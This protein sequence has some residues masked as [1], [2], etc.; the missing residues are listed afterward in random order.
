[1]RQ[2]KIAA[3][4]IFSLLAIS[5]IGL[6]TFFITTGN[7]FGIFS[8]GYKGEAVLAQEFSVL[9]KDTKNIDLDL[10]HNAMDVFV[11][12]GEGDKIVYKEYLEKGW[13]DSELSKVSNDGSTL[14]VSGQRRSFNI[15]F[16]SVNNQYAEI[17]IPADYEKDIT[18]NT[19]SGNVY[20]EGKQIFGEYVNINTSSGDV[21]LEEVTAD[22]ISINTI[23]GNVYGDELLGER[24]FNTSSGDVKILGGKGNTMGN[25]S[26]GNIYLSEATGEVELSTN[27]GDVKLQLTKEES[28]TFL[29]ET[30][31][32]DINTYFDEELTMNEDRNE[33]KGTIGAEGTYNVKIGTSSG[34]VTVFE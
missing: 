30:S 7:G 14:M 1:M 12:V 19:S 24:E 22:Y 25:T 13:S 17:Y 32:G 2:I 9:I 33:A 23:S 21:Q 16:F 26:S 10:S 29:A 34:N 28:F 3:I 18:I 15:Q 20:M 11:Y 4:V 6:M 31:S 27:S 8:V 5:L